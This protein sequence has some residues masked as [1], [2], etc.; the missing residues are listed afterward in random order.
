MAERSWILTDLA[1]DLH[2]DSFSITARELDLPPEVGISISK[3]TLRGGLRDGVEVVEVDNGAL[4]F[5]LLPTRGMGIWKGSYQGLRLGWDS[6]TR[7]PVHPGFV[8]LHDRGGLGW[9]KGF[10]EWICRCGLDSN[11]SP[12]RDTV[13]DNNGTPCSVDLTLHGKIANLPA[14]FLEVSVQTAAPYEIAVTGRVQESMLFAPILLLESRVS[15][16]PGSNSLR[17]RDQ[18]VNQRSEPAEVEL[19][20]H[21]NFGPP[22]LEAGSRL[23]APILE[24]APRDPRATEGI[25]GFRDYLGPT[26]GYIEQ[27]YWHR[28]AGDRATGQ[29]LALLKNS[30]GDRAVALR[31]D[32]RRLPWFTQ[33]KNTGS[34][35]EGYVTGLEPGTDLP[36][37]KPFERARGRLMT[38]AGGASLSFDLTVEVFD[39]LGRVRELEREVEALRAS[40]PPEIH[41]APSPE[42]SDLG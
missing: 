38:V 9:L 20:Y 41:P 6:P 7:G 1:S 21:C 5:T 18:V 42:Y 13:L 11:G 28:L 29:T 15:T 3:R 10:D 8:D 30:A 23:V 35:E 32:S 37:A 25:D 31:Y 17:I 22:F 34:L 40:T 33:W 12:C 14:N 27:V 36:N 26:P 4:Q 2:V 24:A 39:D 16:R 19:L